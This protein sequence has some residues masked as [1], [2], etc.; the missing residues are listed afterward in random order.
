MFTGR[1]HINYLSTLDFDAD[2]LNQV[3]A[4]VDGVK[5]EV[6]QMTVGHAA[7]LDERLWAQVDVLHTSAVLCDPVAAPRLRW[8]QLDTSGVDHLR[9]HPL[10]ESEVDIT[11]LGGVSPVPLAEYVMWAILGTA[12]QLPT[13][14]RTRN[15]RHWP[16][17]AQRWQEMMPAAVRGSTV[18]IVGYGRIGQEIGRLA[19][20]FGMT[21]LALRR[22]ADDRARPAELYNAAPPVVDTPADGAVELFGPDDLPHLLARTDYLV[23]VVPLTDSTAN[24]IDA[25]AL[26]H[27]KHGAV[28]INVARG[29]ILDEEALRAGLRSGAIRAAVL[30]VFDQEPL[31]SGDPWWSEPNAFVTPHVSGLAPDYSA[32]TLEIVRENLQRFASGL[33]LMNLVDRRRGY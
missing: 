29:G 1:A 16:S 11:T 18:G 10:W 12:H 24:M 21:V 8:V 5:V 15:A 33:P 14:L 2:F 32:R 28:V 20:A 26:S 3:A 4:A 25:T 22:T 23:V 17:P 7:Q 9:G 31:G 13:L 27:L 19:R 30:D 6:L